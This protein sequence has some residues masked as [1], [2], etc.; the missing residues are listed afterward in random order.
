MTTSI[1]ATG[2][3]SVLPAYADPNIDTSTFTPETLLL[4]CS[5]RL[6]TLDSTIKEFFAKQEKT[7]KSMQDANR[8]MQILS[9]I[10]EINVGALMDPA[11]NDV[12][13]KAHANIAND[14]LQVYTTTDSPDLKAE[15][16][17]RF[18]DVTG[19]EVG[20]YVGATG[21]PLPVVFTD[22][23][24]TGTMPTVT[25]AMWQAKVDATK[26]VTTNL[27]KG[28][29]LNMI[30]LQSLVSQRQLAIQLTT[31]MMQAAHEAKKQVVSNIRA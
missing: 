15:I 1:Q 14:L 5:S 3:T 24:K 16:A 13:K 30:Q 9:A 11:S 26:S 18:K 25:P 27:S 4:Y 20:A 21:E 8:V 31:Q 23:N 6:E 22:I 10:G 12:H 2:T 29:E 7:N 17:A 28:S 19:N